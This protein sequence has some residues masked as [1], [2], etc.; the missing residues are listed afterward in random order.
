MTCLQKHWTDAEIDD[1]MIP[2]IRELNKLGLKTVSCCSGHNEEGKFKP[3]AQLC[4]ESDNCSVF[5]NNGRVSI[6]W[7][8]FNKKENS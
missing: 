8:R 1:E 3:L 2:V 7:R 5:L 6:N 4:F